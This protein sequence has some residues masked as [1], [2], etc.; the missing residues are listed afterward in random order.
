RGFVGPATWSFS[1]DD[2]YKEDPEDIIIAYAGH[3]TLL[4]G[5]VRELYDCNADQD[6]SEFHSWAENTFSDIC[7]INQLCMPSN[8]LIVE[9]TANHKNSHGEKIKGCWCNNDSELIIGE[10]DAGYTLPITSLYVGRK[11]QKEKAIKEAT[12]PQEHLQPQ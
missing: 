4:D 8:T 5:D 12:I 9:F 6:C 2:A 1:N 7:I 3:I 10:G 11:I